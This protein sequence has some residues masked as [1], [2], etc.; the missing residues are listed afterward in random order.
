MRIGIDAYPLTRKVRSGVSCYVYYLIRNMLEIDKKNE[1]Y[2]YA[3]SARK[4]GLEGSNPNLHFSRNGRGNLLN[5]F[6]TFW[7]LLNARRRLSKDK[8]NI[9]LGTSGVMPLCLPDSVN[10]ALIVYDLTFY[11]YPQT[12]AFDNY[13]IYRFLFKRSLLKAKRIIAISGTTA[14]G[15]KNLFND[16]NIASKI[17][18]I[19]GGVDSDRFKKLERGPSEKYVFNKFNIASRY[20]L[21][22]GNIEP[23]KNIPGLL[24]A[25]YILK[26]RYNIQHQLV[27]VGSKGWKTTQIF[28]AYQQLGF[29]ENEVLFLGYVTEEDLAKL[30]SAA[31]LFIL[32][33]FYEGFGLPPLEAMACGTPVVAS[34]APIFKEILADAALLPDPNNPDDIARKIYEII[35]NADL[36]NSLIHNGFEK[37]QAY[38]WKD[39]AKKTLAI[40]EGMN[41]QNSRQATVN[42]LL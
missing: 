28:K 31:D 8:I 33:S 34:S 5:K 14:D 19:Y 21:F 11:L 41:C 7:M 1:F 29:K 42:H 9:F 23:R 2:L 12:M 26:K 27:I 13:L 18:V 6:S 39:A 4:T 30:Y 35:S 32:P 10:S 3:D 17:S 20:I 22:V 38:S 15:I 24:E 25:F 40:L 37:I 36:R 16:E